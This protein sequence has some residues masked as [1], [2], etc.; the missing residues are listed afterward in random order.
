MNDTPKKSTALDAFLNLLT[1]ITLGWFS[2]SL[3]RLLFVIIDKTI[4][5]ASR[6]DFYYSG[7][8]FSF[9]I[10][11]LLIITPIFLLVS[12][13]LHRQYKENKL[14]K[15][16]VYRWLTYLML[17][18]AA[19]VIAGDL[20]ALVD[21][22][23]GGEYK[24]DTIL[25]IL[26]VF[27]ISLGIFLYY[28]YDMRRTDY[29]KRS[30][31]AQIAFAVVVIVAV[32]TIV[33]GFIVAD[34]PFVARQKKQDQQRVGD[35]SALDANIAEYYRES[36]ALPADLSEKRFAQYVDPETKTSY[37]YTKKEDKKYELCA[38]FALPAPQDGRS[39]YPYPAY[40]YYAYSGGPGEWQFHE[41]GLQCYGREIKE[42]PEKDIRPVPVKPIKQ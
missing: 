39:N 13:I 10:A 34:S 29:N 40:E 11:S 37:E 20:I 38:T 15:G 16:A 6:N 24:I 27:V 41:A 2:I 32:A 26:T 12:G 5:D 17:L 25:K 42:G 35:L 31:L 33:G 30:G 23:L 28:W 1:L 4:G 14:E 7:N 18:V 21:N 36:T 3:G 22:L 8:Q 19:L 9:P